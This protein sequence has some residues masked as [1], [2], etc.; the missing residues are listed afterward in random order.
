MNFHYGMKVEVCSDEGGFNGA[1][2]PVT[3]IGYVANAQRLKFIIEYNSFISDE[4]THGHPIDELYSTYI[5]PLPPV[6]SL[7]QDISVDLVVDVFENNC[8]RTGVVVDSFESPLS[9]QKLFEIF[10]PH[11]QTLQSYSC[12]HLR[13]AHEWVNGRWILK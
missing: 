11:N 1:W 4:W 9:H 12:S 6:V 5:W 7:P 10:F 8:W 2:I 13:R 3:I